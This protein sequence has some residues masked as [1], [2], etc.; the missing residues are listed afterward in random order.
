MRL[1]IAELTSKL[2]GALLNKHLCLYN[3]SS[4]SKFSYG[5]L[6]L[7]VFVEKNVTYI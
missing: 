2:C 6:L 1:I 4:I 7:M 3:S 5:S